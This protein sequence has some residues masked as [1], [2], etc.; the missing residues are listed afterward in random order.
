MII[1]ECIIIH[2]FIGAAIQDY[3]HAISDE[4]LTE[5]EQLFAEEAVIVSP[6]YH[7]LAEDVIANFHVLPPTNFE[8]AMLVYFILINSL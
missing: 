6:L 5:V 1:S 4:I 2:M 8:E 3:K 7:S